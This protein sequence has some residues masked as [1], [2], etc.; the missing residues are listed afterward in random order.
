[1]IKTVPRKLANAKWPMAFLTVLC[2]LTGCAGGDEYRHAWVDPAT[3]ADRAKYNADL[4]ECKAIAK[5]AYDDRRQSDQGSALA[6]AG[7]AGLGAVGGTVIASAVGMSSIYGGVTG[8]L[9]GGDMQSGSLR[10]QLEVLYGTNRQCLI[11]RGYQP[12]Q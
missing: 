10:S 2:S 3:A 11:D 1:M 9:V 12:L 4:D 7:A 5:Q 6:T 8:A